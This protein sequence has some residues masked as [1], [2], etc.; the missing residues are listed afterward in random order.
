MTDTDLAIGR[1]AF[2]VVCGLVLTAVVL[3]G[4]AIRQSR[5]ERRARE[6][7]VIAINTPRPPRNAA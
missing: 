3:I 4:L 6:L 2:Y 1:W 7:Q 5:K